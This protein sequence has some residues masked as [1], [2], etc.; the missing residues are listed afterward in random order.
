[1]VVATPTLDPITGSRQVVG[2]RTGNE[3]AAISAKQINFHLMGYFPITPSTEIAELVDEMKAAG[4]HDIVMVP[5]TANTQ[6]AGSV[7]APR[8][9]AAASST[10]RARRACCT[11]SRSYLCSRGRAIRCCSTSR[12]GR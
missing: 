8:R 6:Q 11:S 9:E 4:E 12:P 5:P 2:F 7:S 3:M 10:P 1:M